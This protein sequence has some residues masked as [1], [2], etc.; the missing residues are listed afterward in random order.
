MAKKAVRIGVS[1]ALMV[2]LLAVFL[3]NVDFEEVGRALAGAD[4]TMLVAAV[5]VALLAYWMRCLRGAGAPLQRSAHHRGRL[6]RT[7]PPAGADG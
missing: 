2:V 3:W 7:L 1:L 6:C 4:L 5:L